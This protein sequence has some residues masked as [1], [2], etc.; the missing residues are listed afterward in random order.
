MSTGIR[1]RDV[2]HGCET[3]ARVPGYQSVSL[4]KA[5]ASRRRLRAVAGIHLFVKKER[6]ALKGGSPASR[7]ARRGRPSSAYVAVAIVR[8]GP[9][10]CTGAIPGFA[11]PPTPLVDATRIG[12]IRIGQEGRCVGKQKLPC[13][14][15]RQSTRPPLFLA[16][17][18]I[19]EASR[20]PAP[21]FRSTSKRQKAARAGCRRPR[22]LPAPRMPFP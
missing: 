13:W 19:R 3:G 22:R 15:R 20:V 5:G 21:G 18:W 8:P 16:R 9:S 12:L 10:F 6:V 11:G 14:P 17:V 1:R 2:I 7:S 4:C